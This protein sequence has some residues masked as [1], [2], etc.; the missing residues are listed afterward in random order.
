[1]DK[2]IIILDYA[3][4]AKLLLPISVEQHVLRGD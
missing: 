2:G 3:A 1:M 4:K